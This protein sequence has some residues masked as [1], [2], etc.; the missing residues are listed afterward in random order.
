MKNARKHILILSSWY[1]NPEH[2]FLG[3]F[4]ERQATL[5]TESY[6]VTVINTFPGENEEV[7]RKTGSFLEIAS[8][9]S[10]Q[11]NI[12]KRKKAQESAFQR[13]LEQ[14][15]DVD[16]IIAHIGLPRGL[17][18]VSAKK[19]LN[20][21]LIYVEHGSYFREQ[22]RN[23]WSFLERII[24]KRLA[25][26]AKRM[27]A[28]SEILKNDMMTVF[29]KR[30]IEVIG[31]PV[32]ADLFNLKTENNNQRTQ[33]LHVS[34][35]DPETKNPY[36]IID[37]CLKLKNRGLDFYLTIVTDESY[38]DLQ[39]TVEEK[40]LKN[41]ISFKGP[42]EWNELVPIYHSADCFV[43]FSNYETFSIAL[44]EALLTGTPII[45][46]PVGIAA[47]MDASNFIAVES[48][49]SG[50][51]AD[52]M[53]DFIMGKQTFDPKS[54]RSNGMNY[55]NERILDTWKELIDEVG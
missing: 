29:P 9:Y 37:A 22:K 4:V 55:S 36:G 50:S 16:L 25:K 28:V 49:N 17:Q 27:V 53:Q 7:V 8:T 12:I 43:L 45:S 13:G 30:E 46:T 1:P 18:F 33:F 6:E 2:P 14:L 24:L 3:N 51:L 20:C 42:L 39:N 23:S 10:R 38:T 52:A 32:D 31:N 15:S 47:E 11:G 26:N 54:L 21:P 41:Y 19:K 5:L 35:L 44:A 34:T 48:R 40:D